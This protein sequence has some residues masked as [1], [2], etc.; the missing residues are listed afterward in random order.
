MKTLAAALA[1][2]AVLTG[3]ALAQTA[4][5]DNNVDPIGKMFVSLD[6]DKSGY[7]DGAEVE[8]FKDKLKFLDT[9]K[10]SKVSQNEFY[11]GVMTGVI[12]R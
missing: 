3:S 4:P 7:L 8:A 11:V 5:T 1:V 2:F 10:D 12:A 6:A 9:D